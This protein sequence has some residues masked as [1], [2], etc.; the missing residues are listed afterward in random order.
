VWT[1]AGTELKAVEVTLGPTD[2][3]VTVLRSGGLA[4]GTPV[5]VDLAPTNQ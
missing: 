2:G 4:P 5:I 3:K 1:E